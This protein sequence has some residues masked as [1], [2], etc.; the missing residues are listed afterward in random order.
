M[1]PRAV[2]LALRRERLVSRSRELRRRV[3]LHAQD[4]Q[5][6]LTWVDRIQDAVLWLRGNPFAA[7]A[8][9]L[10]LS[11]WRPRRAAGFGMR[12]WSAWKLIQR[13]RGAEG[14][15]SARRR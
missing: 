1:T 6:A 8:G 3:V 15:V 7:T 5:P 13:L 10:L 2:Q 12:V 14:D 9:T 11:L 4:L